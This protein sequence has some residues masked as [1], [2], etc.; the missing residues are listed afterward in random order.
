MKA[1]DRPK[2]FNGQPS[3]SDAVKRAADIDGDAFGFLCPTLHPT[4]QA[5]DL[6]DQQYQLLAGTRCYSGGRDA[7]AV[8][9]QSSILVLTNPA[10]SGKIMRVRKMTVSNSSVAGAFFYGTIN[11][12]SGIVPALA[13]IIAVTPATRDSRIQ[14]PLG[15]TATA[16]ATIR[17][18]STA[19]AIQ[20]GELFTLPAAASGVFQCDPLCTI[21]PNSWFYIFGVSANA[22]FNASVSWDERIA[23]K[24]ELNL[25]YQ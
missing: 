17:V 8:V 25:P 5:L 21:A 1:L 11:L 14:N 23:A 15:G 19:G 6:T 12:N 4:I 16:S 22:S 3:I 24:A 13:N 20:L 10:N 2:V 9:G 18:A 7:P